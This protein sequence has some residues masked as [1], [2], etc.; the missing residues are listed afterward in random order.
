M[1][2]FVR[3]FVYFLLVNADFIVQFL[4]SVVLMAL[5]AVRLH[6]TLHLSPHDPLN[7][8]VRFYDHIV[9]ELLI[10]SI[11]TIFWS[12]FIAR[13]IHG[14]HEHRRMNTFTAE[15]VGLFILFLL[16]LIGA[17]VATHTSNPPDVDVRWGNLS[18]CWTYSTCRIL[19]ALLAFAWLG[20]I[21]VLALFVMSLLFAIANKAFHDPM[22]GRWDRRATNYGGDLSMRNIVR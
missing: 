8:G 2:H 11:I 18:S 14:R 22:H 1:I 9:V 17:A 7:G 10:T 19:T 6:Y 15:L 16:W 5:C 4:F 3:V 20:W 21:L 13:T 12:T